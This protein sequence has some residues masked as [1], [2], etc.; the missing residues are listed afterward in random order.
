MARKPT[1][2]QSQVNFIVR[3]YNKGWTAQQLAEKYGCTVTTI[4]NWLRRE[5]VT[6]R[7]RGR[8]PQNA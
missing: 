7:P 1:F 2:N 5:G 6:I 3:N 8:R 4:L